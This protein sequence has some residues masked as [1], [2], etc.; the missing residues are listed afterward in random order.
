MAALSL[1]LGAEKPALR[2][3]SNP[4]AA[5][6]THHHLLRGCGFMRQVGHVVVVLICCIV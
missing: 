4:K 2:V 3:L 1:P 6:L 5:T